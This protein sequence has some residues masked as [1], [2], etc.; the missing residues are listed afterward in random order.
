MNSSHGK[1]SSPLPLWLPRSQASGAPQGR[2][3]PPHRV[4]LG[5]RRQLSLALQSSL[6]TS[7]RACDI[8]CAP[9][10]APPPPPQCAPVRAG[11][12]TLAPTWVWEDRNPG[13]LE[14]QGAPVTRSCPCPGEPH[15]GNLNSCSRSGSRCTGRA[16]PPT[17]TRASVT[18]RLFIFLKSPKMSRLDVGRCVPTAP[19]RTMAGSLGARA[20]RRL[21]L[22][23]TAAEH[24]QAPP[25]GPHPGGPRDQS[26]SRASGNRSLVRLSSPTGPGGTGRRRTTSS[27]VLRAESLGQ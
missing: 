23:H 9:L 5:T 25:T 27:R 17:H 16:R 4:A 2:L 22:S 21:L 13:P 6:P 3:F 19:A 10:P 12:P 15:R 24:R 11:M 8:H 1:K 20:A 18:C 7:A 14:S 26:P